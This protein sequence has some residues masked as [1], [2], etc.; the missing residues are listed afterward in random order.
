MT[1]T[2]TVP[3]NASNEW[4]KTP[5]RTSIA[6]RAITRVVSAVSAD[7]LGVPTGKVSVDVQD[8]G[9]RLSL[10][11]SAP[12]RTPS[13]LRIENEPRVVDRQG[14]PILERAKRAQEHIR[15][16]VQD[17]TGHQVARVIVTITGVDIQEERRVK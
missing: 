5:G 4:D 16:R 13:L 1:I 15:T 11:V 3:T 10:T 2:E 8:D 17:L 12:I 14:G 6:T 7:T 9:G